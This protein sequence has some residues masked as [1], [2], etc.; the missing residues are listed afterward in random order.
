MQQLGL[1]L[2][3]VLA[4]MAMP[5]YA[6]GHS[7]QAA[8]P[9]TAVSVEEFATLKADFERLVQRFEDLAAENARLRERQEQAHAA[10]ATIQAERAGS[11]WTENI[12]LMGDFRYRYQ[13]DDVDLPAHGAR[14]RQRVRA[15][16]AIIARL[17]G[18]T[19]VGFGLATGSSDPASSNQTLGDGGSSKGINLDLAYVKWQVIDDLYLVAGK[20]KN[21]MHR[22]GG[23]GLLWDSDWRPEGLEMLYRRGAFFA[24]ALGTWLEADASSGS[25]EIFAWG[26]Q[27]G[28][29]LPV[30]EDLKL[31]AGLSY[32]DIPVKG[33]E[34]LFDA[35]DCFGN[36]TNVNGSY[37][38][39]FEEFNLFAELGLEMLGLPSTVFVDYVR[40]TA[41]AANDTGYA[42]GLKLGKA[43]RQGSWEVAY[44][45]Q[46]LEADA[47]LGLLTDSNF[48]GGGTDSKGH[49]FGAAY[50]LSDAGK[51]K[52]SYFA[53]ERQDSNGVEN[54]GNK[55]DANT[56]QL[57][58]S[59]R[60]Q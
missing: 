1:V 15:R 6:A 4:S 23:N 37:R 12:R 39:D 17:P 46:D 14:N 57:D 49:R 43:N 58:F 24:N 55:Y 45:Y 19:E 29:D 40:N 35:G 20:F 31:K 41:A 34:C 42:L 30:G 5:V 18:R 28:V 59:W 32:Y 25:G 54:G 50:A 8:T 27:G 10:V 48:G 52:L 21:D 7:R 56:L 13:Y 26:A 16:P 2:V 36:S 9:A 47:V 3:L 51:L 60:Y 38:F 44:L 22:T 11:S 53:T 33:E